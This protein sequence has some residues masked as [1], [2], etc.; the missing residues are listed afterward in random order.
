MTIAGR[1]WADLLEHLLRDGILHA[2]PDQPVVSGTGRPAPWMLDSLG[3]SLDPVGSRLAAECLLEVLDQF[4]ASQLATYGVTALPLLMGCIHYGRGRYRGIVVRK[5]PRPHGSLKQIEGIVDPSEPVIIIDDSICSGYSMRTCAQ[6]LEGAGLQVEGAASLVRFSYDPGVTSM[7]DRGYRMATVFDLDS[8]LINLI[9]GEG[10][11]AANPTKEPVE[12]YLSDR[13]APEGLHPAELARAVME[14]YL[15]TGRVLGPPDTVD[16]HYDGAGGCFVS[17]RRRADVHTRPARSGFWHF[18][19]EPVGTGPADLTWAAI[20]TARQLTRLPDPALEL[21]LCGIAVTFFSALEECTVGELDNDRYGIVVR[22][23]DRPDRMGGALP[24]MPGVAGERQQFAH[25]LRNARLH[26]LEPYHLY[27]H[28]VVKVV[29]PGAPWHATGVP[30][31]A[32]GDPA[33]VARLAVHARQ[34]VLGTRPATTQAI[35]LPTDTLVFVTVYAKGRLVGCLGG[36]L[37]PD[38]TAIEGYALGALD[39]DRFAAAD[40]TDPTR[41]AVSVSVLSNRH[42]IGTADPDW[43]AGPTRHGVQALEVRQGDRRAL[44]LPSVA[45]THNFTPKEFIDEVIDK[46]GITRPPYHWTRYDVATALAEAGGVHEMAYGLPMGDPESVRTSQLSRLE[47]LLLGYVRCHHDTATDTAT[48]TK[49]PAIGRYEPFADRLRIGISG[50]RFAY[51]AWVKARAGLSAEAAD[52]VRRLEA[53]MGEDGWIRFDDEPA[54]ISELA[55]LVLAELELGDERGIVA[56]LTAKLWSRIDGHGRFEIQADGDTP[57]DDVYQDY[58]PGQA[59]LAAAM[60]AR[61]RAAEFDPVVLA[62]ALRYYRMRFRQN[63]DWGAVAWLAQAFAAWGR[64]TEDVGST[65]FAYEIVDWALRFQSEKS[66]GFLNDHQPDSP[67]ATT[68]VYL[69]AV[70]AVL[71]AANEEGDTERQ[72]RYRLAADRGLRFLDRLVYQ[73]RD[74]LVLPNPSWAIGGVRTSLSAS[75]VRIDYVQHALSAVLALKPVWSEP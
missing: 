68:A 64:L 56:G 30:A 72:H 70:A 23:S 74:A 19:G 53:A 26:R 12:T 14:E 41:L 52:D 59:L 11:Y 49:G 38:Q 3:V 17:L 35:D 22:S 66:G 47:G 29:E 4:E 27:R 46:A 44:L 10:P 43:V 13:A 15:A 8:D 24:S 31:T 50:A 9:D 16:R 34:S 69:E 63:H 39:D 20:Q 40:I 54:S 65:A 57:A 37:G 36:P 2:S 55:F 32:Q 51:G 28:D 62:K 42:E 33:K 58:A 1:R 60:A 21:E 61:S 73:Q 45:I 67:G 25:A 5:Q 18:P 6:L 71:V 7:L 48:A 75:E